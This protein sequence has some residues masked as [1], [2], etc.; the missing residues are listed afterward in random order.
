MLNLVAPPGNYFEALKMFGVKFCFFC[1][2][3]C[4]LGNSAVC[5]RCGAVMCIA[6]RIGGAGCIG[7]N[8][9][10][11]DKSMFECPVCVG[12]PRT[13]TKVLPYYLT[14]SGLLRTPKIAWPLL[15]MAIEHKNLDSL[16][17]KLVSLTMESNYALD[18]EHVRFPETPC[19]PTNPSIT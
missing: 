4:D 2:D 17:V 10:A 7:F 14:G 11:V 5:I 13:T 1:S 15:L 16:V 8:T 9:L 12:S 6:T 19:S 18:K 3:P